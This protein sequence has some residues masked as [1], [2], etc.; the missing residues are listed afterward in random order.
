VRCDIERADAILCFDATL[1]EGRLLA[2]AD[3]RT[4]IVVNSGRSRGDLARARPGYRFV[5]VDAIAIARAHGL[6]RIVNSVLLGAFARAVGSRRLLPCSRRSRSAR[7]LTDENLAALRGR[8]RSGRSGLPRTT[9]P[10][11]PCRTTPHEPKGR[12]RANAP[13]SASARRV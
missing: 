3:D 5:P 11:Q 6:G 13:R 1:L 7:A 2:A 10:T 8:L 12:P 4:L 9:T